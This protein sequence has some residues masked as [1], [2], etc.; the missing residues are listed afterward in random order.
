[1]TWPAIL[2]LA[3]AA[4]GCKLAGLVFGDRLR[5][6]GVVERVLVQLP[7][8]VLAAV[9]VVLTVSNERSIAIDARAA[10]VVAGAV[11]AWQRV[12]FVGVVVV[13]AATTAVMRAV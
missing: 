9:V 3:M 6:I 7:V 11:A 12:P 1:M 8:A 13:A 5:G 4:Y 2:G 10:G